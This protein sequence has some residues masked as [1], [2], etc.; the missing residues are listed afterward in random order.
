MTDKFKFIFCMKLQK[1]IDKASLG[2]VLEQTYSKLGN[3]YKIGSIE[4]NSKTIVIHVTTIKR[5][6]KYWVLSITIAKKGFVSSMLCAT[7][8]KNGTISKSAVYI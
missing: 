4:E 3:N 8:L 6:P 7:L 2:K 1:Y 5:P